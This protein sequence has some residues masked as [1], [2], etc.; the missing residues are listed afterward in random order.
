M[1]KFLILFIFILFFINTSFSQNFLSTKGTI[2]TI[3]SSK[4]KFN[5]NDLYNKNNG[6][7]G[8]GTVNPTA[9]LHT[10]G[11]FRLEGIGNNTINTRILTADE[12]GNI[13]TRLL[14]NLL[15]GNSISSSGLIKTD[16]GNGNLIIANIGTDYSAGTS[17]LGTGILK[18]YSGTGTLSIAE[19]A[20]FPILNQ[21][22][23]GNAATVTT[24]ANLVGP[25]TSIGNATSILNNVISNTMLSK[26]TSQSFKGRSSAGIGDVEDMTPEQA[27]E[28][29]KVFTSSSKGLVPASNGALNSFL[30]ADGSF[31]TIEGLGRSMVQL[32]SDVINNN[33]VA[34]TLENVTGLFFNVIANKIYRFYI[35]IPYT[36]EATNNGS[37]WTIDG[38]TTSFISYVS[39][40]TLNSTTESIN[41]CDA[42]NLP[43]VCNNNSR[44]TGNIAIIQ[45]FIVPN[46]NGIVQVKFA[47]RNSRVAIVAKAGA[48]LEYW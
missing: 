38:P 41:F 10:T 42:I 45:G 31:A 15:L 47:S 46:Q 33:P 1:H 3:D 48:S 16:G 28:M 37:R 21:N 40:Y 23:N 5:G 19:A 32:F 35:M 27:T 25:V 39:R 30:R 29:L 2:F 36:S 24:N 8:I 7:I 18:S 12:N 44:S 17:L 43:A 11:T 22:T 9:Q 20:D 34:N 14:S 6:N 13:S 26:M 4:W